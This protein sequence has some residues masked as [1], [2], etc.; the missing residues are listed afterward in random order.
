MKLNLK[1]NRLIAGAIA[2]LWMTCTAGATPFLS[3]ITSMGDSLSDVGNFYAITGGTQ[4][5]PP[6][7]PGRF[8]NGEVWVEYL[9]EWLNLPIEPEYQYALGGSSTGTA[10]YN[11]IPPGFILPGFQQQVDGV[12]EDSGTPRIDPRALYTVWVGANDFFIWLGSGDPNALGMVSN[13]VSNTVNGIEELAAAG[14][15]NFLVVNVPD[16]G[17]TP[18]AAVLP[19][20]VDGL[21][22]NLC[23]AWNGLLDQKLDELEAERPS[24]RITRL[25]SFALINDMIANPADYGF[26]NVTDGAIYHLPSAN[27]DDYLFWDPVHPTTTAHSY[28]AAAAYEALQEDYVIYRTP[29]GKR[30]QHARRCDPVSVS[31]GHARRPA[32]A[33]H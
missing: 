13:G 15:R 23:V 11:S 7:A 22:T 29:A 14:A 25:D 27:P 33:G 4:P 20:G 21:L 5:P 16:L 24:L 26:T 28:V 1:N 8:S 2:S 17:K 6:Y 10:N 30:G 12:I 31:P 19:P 32:W 3:G 18:S 9:A